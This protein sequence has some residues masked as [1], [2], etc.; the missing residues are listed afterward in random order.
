VVG[1]AAG[2][3]APSPAAASTKPTRA[4]ALTA[5][6][7]AAA[8]TGPAT[9][10]AAPAPASQAPL[11]GSEPQA[12]SPQREQAA[13]DRP[14][15]SAETAPKP[16]SGPTRWLPAEGQYVYDLSGTTSTGRLPA[17]SALAIS[18]SGPNRQRWSIDARDQ[19]GEGWQESF[20][21]QES[22][23]GLQLSTYRLEYFSVARVTIEFELS[24][25]AVFVPR[26]MTVGRK[27]AFDAVTKDGCYRV[28]SDGV[29]AAADKA[30]SAGA[31]T[32][33]ADVLETKNSLTTVGPPS[34]QRLDLNQSRRTA[35]D[36]A[37]RLVVRDETHSTGTFAGFPFQSDVTALIRSTQPA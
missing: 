15:A 18:S 6:T 1:A 33:Q 9:A 3:A 27:W 22:S 5:T 8:A 36:R 21:V 34:C 14:A 2:Q 7:T 28:H 23:D 31:F 25:A 17:S 19:K 20:G 24:P 35:F 16:S 37:T 32:Y 11:P 4:A 12:A 26:P 10:A 13:P 29:V 30:V